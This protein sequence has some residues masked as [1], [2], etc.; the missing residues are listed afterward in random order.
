[1]F[2]YIFDPVRLLM[3]SITAFLWEI[4]REQF[5]SEQNIFYENFREIFS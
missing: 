5:R 1:M 2:I 4:L 3:Y